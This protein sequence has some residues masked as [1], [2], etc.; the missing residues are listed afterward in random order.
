MR[1]MTKMGMYSPE[2]FFTSIVIVFVIVLLSFRT[3]QISPDL[4]A[5]TGTY[6]S[7]SWKSCTIRLQHRFYNSTHI[8]YN[9]TMIYIY[10]YIYMCVYM[11]PSSVSPPPLPPP[12]YLFPIYYLCTLTTLHVLNIYRTYHTFQ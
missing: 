6:L 4:T 10:I 3:P 5:L 2:P 12:Q 1:A 8:L 11:V 7:L 9:P